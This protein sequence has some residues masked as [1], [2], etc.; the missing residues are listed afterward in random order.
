V[1]ALPYVLT[2]AEVDEKN[3]NNKDNTLKLEVSGD[4]G[5]FKVEPGYHFIS[6]GKGGTQQFKTPAIHHEL[7]HDTYVAVLGREIE[8]NDAQTLKPGE[9]KTFNVPDLTLN[10][11]L[12]YTI[13]YEK[14]DREGQVGAAGTK[15]L[16]QLSVSL[17]SGQKIKAA[18]GMAVA[19]GAGPQF[20]PA[21]VDGEF[22]LT[23]SRMNAADKSVD[24]QMNFVHPIYYI[25]LFYKPMTILVWL[26]AGI[27][28]FG[29]L[30][31]A[32]YRRKVLKAVEDLDLPK[33]EPSPEPKDA[34][35]T[36]T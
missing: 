6:D 20:I 11:N 29:G 26:G 10:Q 19:G 36:A 1:S 24:L 25:D 9:T 28:T 30:L 13:T 15:F 8:A 7:S 22:F 16:A 14:L 2:L 33:A 12:P 3:L 21:M 18:P 32:W 4:G 35:V 34:L 31:S 17:P 23:M 5:K 27:L